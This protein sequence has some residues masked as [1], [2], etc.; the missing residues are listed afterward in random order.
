MRKP[1][2]SASR[3]IRRGRPGRHAGAAVAA[4]VCFAAITHGSQGVCATPRSTVTIDDP[5]P[6]DR[7]LEFLQSKYGYVV[8]YEDPRYQYGDD[9]KDVSREATAR[10]RTLV[11]VGGAVSISVPDNVSDTRTLGS[12]VHQLLQSHAALQTGGHFRVLEEGGVLHVVPAEVRDHNGNWQPQVPVLDLAITIPKFTNIDGVMMLQSICE[13]LSNASG[14]PVLV[15]T[16]PLNML[17]QHRGDLEA[18]SEVA[19]AVLLRALA[20]SSPSL[21]WGLLYDAGIRT[22]FLNVRL[23]HAPISPPVQS[24]ATGVPPTR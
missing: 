14:T 16:M 5:R 4:L 23:I 15:G 22:Y 3:G 2:H 21:S 17:S 18:N 12:V 7:A 19:R 6:I 11:P 8:T 20:L 24:G 1:M 13:A 10:V 9:L